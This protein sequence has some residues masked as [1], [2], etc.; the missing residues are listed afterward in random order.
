ML[1]KFLAAVLCCYPLV[2]IAETHELKIVH[3]VYDINAKSP[4]LMYQFKPDFLQIKLG[5]QVKFPG[6]VGQHTVHSVKGMIPDGAKKISIMPHRP[7]VVTFTEPGVYG[8]KCKI[9]QRHG[10]VAV[11]VVDQDIHNLEVAR[12]HVK[13]GVSAF[14]REK[15]H[16]LLDRAEASVE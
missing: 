1:R 15:M 11:I 14:T 12:A 4:D 9:H 8:L 5:D 3:Q 10:M 7:N 16:R 2:G 13:R 6:T